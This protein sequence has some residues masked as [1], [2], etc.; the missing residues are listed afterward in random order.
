MSGPKKQI[1]CL[2]CQEDKGV[3]AF[4]GGLQPCGKCRNLTRA[5]NILRD[6]GV[7]LQVVRNLEPVIRLPAVGNPEPTN[8]ESRSRMEEQKTQIPEEKAQI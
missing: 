1:Q 3:S 8:Q 4:K 2:Q 5:V 6:T 7:S